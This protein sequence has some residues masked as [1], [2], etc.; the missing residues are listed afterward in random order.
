ML[1]SAPTDDGTI[2][3]ALLEKLLPRDL[4]AKQRIIVHSDGYLRR[5]TLRALGSWE[6]ELDASLAPVEVIRSGVPRMYALKA[7]K[8]EPPS[9]GSVLKLSSTK[10]FVQASESS[11]QP[12][13]LRCEA[14]LAIEEAIHSVLLFTLLHYGALKLPKLPVTVHNADPIENGIVRGV[15]P[16]AIETMIPFWL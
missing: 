4:L 6:D 5:E 15:M 2:P 3:D 7:G 16:S 1:A 14:P 9:W 11:L 13:Y 8:I 10:A 12:L